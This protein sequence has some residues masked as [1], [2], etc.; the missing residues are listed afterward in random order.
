MVKPSTG[1]EAANV[2]I[3]DLR[4]TSFTFRLQIRVFS[5]FNTFFGCFHTFFFGGGEEILNFGTQEKLKIT[6]DLVRLSQ[7]LSHVFRVRL[8]SYTEWIEIGALTFKS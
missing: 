6:Q 7:G 4:H 8:I 1:K 5:F 2:L 3:T